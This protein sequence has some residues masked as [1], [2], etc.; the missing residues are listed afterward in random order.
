MFYPAT[1]APENRLSKST[2]WSCT[3]MS[4]CLQVTLLDKPSS[5]YLSFVH[6]L[7]YKRHC[8]VWCPT[9]EKYVHLPECQRSISSPRCTKTTQDSFCCCCCSCCHDAATQCKA[10]PVCMRRRY[11]DV[12][13]TL[14][15]SVCFG[16]LH[17]N[18]V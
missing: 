7:F 14:R 8:C 11:K 10:R 12:S 3:F 16:P 18:V 9:S 2:V 5:L 4:F 17:N 6:S 13:K 1:G 15:G